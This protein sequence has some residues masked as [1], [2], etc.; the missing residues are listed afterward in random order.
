MA[1]SPRREMY[2]M[3]W[4][5]GGLPVMYSGL[6]DSDWDNKGFSGVISLTLKCSPKL[7]YSIS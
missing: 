3:E 4:G 2:G 1:E 6:D 5:G 7:L